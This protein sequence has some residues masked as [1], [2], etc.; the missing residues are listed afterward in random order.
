MWCIGDMS[1][2]NTLLLHANNPAFSLYIH[3]YTVKKKS[4]TL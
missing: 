2:A 1:A 3:V 4:H